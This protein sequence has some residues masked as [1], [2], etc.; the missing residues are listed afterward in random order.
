MRDSPSVYP[1]KFSRA[2]FSL[3]GVHFIGANEYVNA[4]DG[5]KNRAKKKVRETRRE[6]R[7]KYQ[8]D[9]VL[10]FFDFVERDRGA[11]GET[12]RS[13]NRYR[14]YPPADVRCNVRR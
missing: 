1:C 8:S 10:I 14:T 12:N 2:A 9:G 13:D 7:R 3:F 4:V 11:T 6:T 5:Q